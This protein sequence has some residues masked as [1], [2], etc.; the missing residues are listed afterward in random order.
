MFVLVEKKTGG[1]YAVKD[2]KSLERIV[3][4]FAV[5]DDADRYHMMLED[6]D[7]PRELDV[8]EVARKDVISNCRQHGYRYAIITENDFGVPPPSVID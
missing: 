1:V 4:I 2:D 5:K 7:F 6:V 3:Q 8:A